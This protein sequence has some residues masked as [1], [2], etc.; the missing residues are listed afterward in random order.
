MRELSGTPRITVTIGRDTRPYFAFI[1]TAPA[2]LDLPSTVTVHTSTVADADPIAHDEIRS[3]MPARLV[4]V[5][6]MKRGWQKA[7]YRGNQHLVVPAD[8]QLAGL[9]DLER[10]L[11]QRLQ[12]PIASGVP[13]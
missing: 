7:R 6:A 4:L 3:R 5:D 1:T 12:A 8:P 13:A 11:W 10:W 2:D 9:N